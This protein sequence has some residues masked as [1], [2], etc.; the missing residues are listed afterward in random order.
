MG[1]SDQMGEIGKM[2]N[3]DQ[4]RKIGKMA[5][6]ALQPWWDRHEA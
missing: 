5:G 3:S 6:C 1:N 2:G 4:I